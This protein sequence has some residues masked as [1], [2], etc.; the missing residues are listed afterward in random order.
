MELRENPDTLAGVFSSFDEATW[1]DKNKLSDE[2]LK[3]SLNICQK[4]MW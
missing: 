1:T 4:S 3:I 2:R